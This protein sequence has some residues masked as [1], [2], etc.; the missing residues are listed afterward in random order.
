MM[1]CATVTTILSDHH[2]VRGKTDPQGKAVMTDP[3]GRVALIDPQGRVDS[4]LTDHHRNTGGM[5]SEDVVVVEGGEVVE[6]EVD[7]VADS[8]T[9][10]RLKV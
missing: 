9:R 5:E 2:A 7:L 3:R 1:D 8:V 6:A 4:V 10:G